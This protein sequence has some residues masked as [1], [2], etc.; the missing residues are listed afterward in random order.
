MA[1]DLRQ[2]KRQEDHSSVASAS[3]E[4]RTPKVVRYKTIG[5]WLLFLALALI[6]TVGLINAF[7]YFK[8]ALFDPDI[9]DEQFYSSEILHL[10]QKYDRDENHYLSLDEFEPLAAQFI[11]KHLPTDYQQPILKTD[12]LV[13]IDAYFEP[14]NLSTMTK[15]FQNEF[16][17]R[18]T[19]ISIR[20]LA[21]VSLCRAIST[22]SN[23]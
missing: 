12:Q 22:N 4:G 17:V 8:S 16:L 2:R 1:N 10:F 18:T 20:N 5:Q 13:T 9:S 14:L 21:M 3:I 6:L 15:D 23:F 11:Q 7:H 19:A